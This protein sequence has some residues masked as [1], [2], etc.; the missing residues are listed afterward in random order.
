MAGVIVR[1]MDT[2]TGQASF[3]LKFDQYGLSSNH[4]T[5]PIQH[6]ETLFYLLTN[7]VLKGRIENYCNENYNR[8]MKLDFTKVNHVHFPIGKE[9][10]A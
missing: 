3:N 10:W 7:W 8:L 4:R 2:F 5:I 1:R 6:L 9:R